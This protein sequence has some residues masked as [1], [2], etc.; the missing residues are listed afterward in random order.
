MPWLNREVALPSHVDGV[1]NFNFS[2]F[3]YYYYY[4]LLLLLSFIFTFFS[5]FFLHTLLLNCTVIN[6]II[7]PSNK[8]VMLKSS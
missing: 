8:T 7:I 5:V 3:Y 6:S 1:I 2:S 4:L